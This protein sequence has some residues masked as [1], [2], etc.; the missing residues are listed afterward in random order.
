MTAPFELPDEV[1]I[2]LTDELASPADFYLYSTAF[3]RLK[4]GRRVL[5]VSAADDLARW[6]AVAGK[7]GVNSAQ[8][9]VNKAFEYYD[10]SA[11][12][13]RVLESV[14]QDGAPPLRALYDTIVD[15]LAQQEAP[16]LI[17]LDALPEMLWLGLPEKDVRLFCR[18]L[19][20]LCLKNHTGLL[21]RFHTTADGEHDELLAFLT[22][23][24]Q[25]RVD[26]CPLASGRSGL[27]SGEIVLRRGAS[28]FVQHMNVKTIPRSSALQ[29]R[30]S[31]Y[32]VMYF[33]KGTDRAVL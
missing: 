26:V 24:C 15:R 3:Q 27:V 4:G 12:L 5:V 32:S 22:Q 19:R 2:L 33:E 25:F 1:C 21:I 7:S 31:D 20:A 10:V 11:E 13:D 28:C 16:S 8:Q 9:V 18:A 17:I 23:L 6:K 14:D 30:L 29:Y